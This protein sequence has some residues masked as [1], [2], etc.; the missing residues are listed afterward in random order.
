MVV[1]RRGDLGGGAMVKRLVKLVGT[2]SLVG[3]AYSAYDAF[4]HTILLLMMLKSARY[5]SGS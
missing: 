5:R 4:F 3:L 2:V 1:L